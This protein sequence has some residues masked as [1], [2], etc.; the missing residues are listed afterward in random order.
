M[1]RLQICKNFCTKN[2]TY[3]KLLPRIYQNLLPEKRK[4]NITEPK[5]RQENT[6]AEVQFQ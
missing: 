1:K 6:Y 5:E 2:F 3:T 4:E